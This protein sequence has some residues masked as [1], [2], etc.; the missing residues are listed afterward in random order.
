MNT[1]QTHRLGEMSQKRK[2]EEF[3]DPDY[4]QDLPDTKKPKVTNGDESNNDELPSG[5]TDKIRA[6][7]RREFERELGQKEQ[8]LDRI[9]H[10]LLQAKRLLQRVRYAVVFDYYTKKN[11]EYSESELRNELTMASASSETVVVPDQ[12]EPVIPV[13]KAVHPS[14]KKLLGKKTIDYDEILKMRPARQAAKDAKTSISEK[15]RS[16]K[17]ERKLRK[18][19][20]ETVTSHAEED[21][22]KVP[23][24][25]S[26][27]KVDR[28][29]DKINTARGR[30]QTRHLIAVGNTSKY[31]GDDKSQQ[32]VTH[33]WLVYVKT[34]T[35][36]A[37][38]D[39]IVSKVRFFLHPSY[40]PN[41]VVEVE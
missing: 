16:K 17:E 27:M 31:I 19:P 21:I 10:K 9:E 20:T 23:R 7:V 22:V 2:F 8:E 11:L 1:Q 36:E 26:P 4:P 38:V 12:S 33:K 15:M 5:R 39:E 32:G 6:I 40:S 35:D 29:I 25:I 28:P 18:M 14:L 30:N 3:H 34:K 37:T 13:Q 41:D 24:Y